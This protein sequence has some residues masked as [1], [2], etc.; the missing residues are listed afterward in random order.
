M[1]CANQETNGNI[2]IH[3]VLCFNK[4]RVRKQRCVWWC[5]TLAAVALQSDNESRKA[6][7]IEWDVL[8]AADVSWRLI[9]CV[10]VCVLVYV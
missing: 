3:G 5:L 7:M 4:V 10:R 1:S 9:V 6:N 2:G 8:S